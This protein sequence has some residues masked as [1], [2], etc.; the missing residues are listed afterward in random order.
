MHHATEQTGQELQQFISAPLQPINEH[1]LA[2]Y[3][4][5]SIMSFTVCSF[6]PDLNVY[7]VYFLYS[8]MLPGVNYGCSFKT[9]DF[10]F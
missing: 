5:E 9:V 1:R 10:L 6:R 3:H 2:L 7:K 8:V 4:L